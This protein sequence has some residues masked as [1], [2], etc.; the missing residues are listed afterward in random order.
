VCKRKVCV[1]EREDMYVRE[2]MCTSVCEREGMCVRVCVRK[3]VYER[4]RGLCF[5]HA[6]PWIE[7][8]AWILRE[9]FSEP[10]FLHPLVRR[11]A[12]KSL[13]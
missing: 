13:T 6:G 5:G 10:R 3:G 4:K 9:N 8:I 12:L 11:K 2:G 7:K 1:C